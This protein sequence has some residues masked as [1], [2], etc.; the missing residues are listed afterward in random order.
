MSER[1]RKRIA[2]NRSRRDSSKLVSFQTFFR[3]VFL[4]L[5]EV[6]VEDDFWVRHTVPFVCKGWNE[7]H[8]SQDGSP[9]H[10]TL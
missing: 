4:S 6:A 3:F 9:L 10:E 7:L 8:S 5:H 1:G 2:K